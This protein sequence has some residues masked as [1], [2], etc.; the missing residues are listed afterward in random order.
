MI[1]SIFFLFFLFISA[2][3]YFIDKSSNS[4]YFN[5]CKRNDENYDYYHNYY[6]FI[7]KYVIKK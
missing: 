1:I 3:K 5:N 7:S 2:T 6:N 4:T